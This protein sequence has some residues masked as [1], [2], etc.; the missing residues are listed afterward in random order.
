MTSADRRPTTSPTKQE[1]AGPAQRETAERAR[2]LSALHDLGE[3]ARNGGLDMDV[4]L[5]KRRHRGGPA[6]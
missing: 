5:D 2:R 6:A 1:T 4:L 3:I